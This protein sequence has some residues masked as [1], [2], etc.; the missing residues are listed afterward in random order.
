MQSTSQI[1]LIMARFR[2]PKSADEEKQLLNNKI[3]AST[4]YSTKWSIKIFEE[5]QSS[6]DNSEPQKESWAHGREK[7][8]K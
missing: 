1:V 4:L 7:L 8:G 5:W 2:Q 3:P 6:R